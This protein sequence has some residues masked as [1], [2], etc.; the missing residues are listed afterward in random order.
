MTNTIKK[1][2]K[3]SFL[4]RID[5]FGMIETVVVFPLFLV[6]FFGM[7]EFGW[8]YMKRYVVADA[9]TG[10]ASAIRDQ[11]KITTTALNTYTNSFDTGVLGLSNAGSTFNVNTQSF[12]TIPTAGQV[13]A[14]CTYGSNAKTWKYNNP[15]LGG[16][17]NDDNNAYYVAVCVTHEYNYLTKLIPVTLGLSSTAK[18]QLK[19][20]SV[21][22][23]DSNLPVCAAGKQP[24]A[25]AD[26]TYN[27][28]SCPANQIINSAGLCVNSTITCPA[29]QFLTSA[30]SCSAVS[31]SIDTANC[32]TVTD[33]NPCNYANGYISVDSKSVVSYS[34]SKEQT[35]Q[36]HWLDSQN[37]GQWCWSG[38]KYA[39]E[40]NSVYLVDGLE[41][42]GGLLTE[43]TNLHV[44]YSHI[45]DAL[46]AKDDNTSAGQAKVVNGGK[47]LGYDNR[48][49]VYCRSISAKTTQ[50]CC[51]L[52]IN[53]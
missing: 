38:G 44:P 9:A 10:I 6:M 40:T 18:K 32:T 17:T 49:R 30:G 48:L 52:K 22:A 25:Q 35:W 12:K 45:Q 42:N 2:N 53:K 43:S 7:M 5:G 1:N 31:I 34:D 33:N 23:I 24:V 37:H 47:N 19:S 50:K 41:T 29:G 20:T 28:V 51:R 26:G 11:P 15:W 14:L 27:C 46:D 36:E 4:R 21:V 13:E 8:M 39:N 16:S 3:N